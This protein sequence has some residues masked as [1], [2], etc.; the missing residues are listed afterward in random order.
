MIDRTGLG[1]RYDFDLTWSAPDLFAALEEQL[2]LKIQLTRVPL[3]VLVID[4]AG[5]PSEN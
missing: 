5:K 2:G 3:N 4:Q 1:G